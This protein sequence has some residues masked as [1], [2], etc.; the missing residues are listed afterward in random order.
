MKVDLPKNKKLIGAWWEP[1]DAIPS[2]SGFRSI[3]VAVASKDTIDL[4]LNGSGS[5]PGVEF[6]ILV[7]GLYGP[8]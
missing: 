6:R 4:T 3:S 8:E 5:K 1:V 2:L 7:L